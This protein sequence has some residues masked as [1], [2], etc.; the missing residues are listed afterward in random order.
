MSATHYVIVGN[1]V[2]GMTAAIEL[3]GRDR[4]ARISIISRES[5]HFFSRTAL[6]Y[7]FCG[8]LSLRDLEPY[9]RDFYKTMHFERISV[10]VTALD[11]QKRLLCLADGSQ[12]Q[13]DKL[14]IACG[15]VPAKASWQKDELQNVGHFVTLQDLEWLKETTRGTCPVRRAVVVGGGLIGV[16]VAEVL[17]LEG[18]ETHFIIR[19]EWYWPIAL[20]KSESALVARHMR[21]HGL[22]V[23]LAK[24]IVEVL[25]DGQ[26]VRQVRLSDKQ[27]FDIDLL[28]VAIGVRPG[29]E[30]LKNSGIAL[31]SDRFS[32]IEVD[33]YLKTNCAGIYAAGDCASVEWF[34]G[35]RRPEQLWYTARDQG[36][37]AARNMLGD[38]VCY[39]RGALYN[40]A[41]F[42]DIEYTTAGLVNFPQEGMSEWY[43]EQPEHFRSQ[44]IVVQDSRVVGFNMLGSRWNHRLFVDWIEQRRS[45]EYVLE[46]LHQA[47]F[48]AEFSDPFIVQS[49]S[50]G[51]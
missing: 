34:D 51:S 21:Q 2:A 24:E 26:R 49:Y 13:F 25:D 9:E 32:A 18:I 20:N 7:E 27:V 6:M 8:Q 3:R 48:D 46:N 42:F 17:L 10:E 16:E 1:G 36:L 50:V 33:G 15:S 38:E 11:P 23:H 45:L 30:W 22:H 12:L 35:T 19:E 39:K 14:L 31:S 4:Q 47:V 41:K 5:E 44:R 29:T 28:V 43:Q 37:V 40:S